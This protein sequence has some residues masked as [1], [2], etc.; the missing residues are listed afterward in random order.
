MEKDLCPSFFIIKG[1]LASVLWVVSGPI[2]QVRTV[3][4]SAFL[5]RSKQ[6]LRDR[7]AVGQLTPPEGDVSG[8]ARIHGF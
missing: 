8:S 7:L 4:G 1:Q 5:E 2:F 6:G 3:S